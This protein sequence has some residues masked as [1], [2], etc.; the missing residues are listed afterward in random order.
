[1]IHDIK[2]AFETRR[3][4]ARLEKA[5]RQGERWLRAEATASPQAADRSL[6]RVFRF[7]PRPALAA[8]FTERVLA[9]VLPLLP[10]P[11]DPFSRGTVR[12]AIAAAFVLVGTLFGGLPQLLVAV[13]GRLRAGMVIEVVQRVPVVLSDALTGIVGLWPLV[14]T[15]GGTLFTSLSSPWFLT[16][17]VT[18][19]L[20]SVATMRV[21][22]DFL[23]R[24]KG[25]SHVHLA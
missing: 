13:G 21:V 25:F 9:Q 17:L 11:R 24:Q 3:N 18:L 5:R 19:T 14:S 7:I 1:M 16:A 23:V 10:Q 6:R 8:G 2:Q 12:W 15:L 22:T 20:M 4:E